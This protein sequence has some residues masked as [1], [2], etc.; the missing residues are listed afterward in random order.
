MNISDDREIII[1]IKK[2]NIDNFSFLVKKY[3]PK[4]YG[5]VY[6]KLFNK[7]EVDDLVQNAFFKF[8]KAIG[9]F[10]EQR[11]VLP[12]L[13]EIAKN[14]MKMYFRS[15]KK[16][17]NF[18]YTISVCLDYEEKF[19]SSDINDGLKI[20]NQDQRQ[21]LKLL[22]DGYSYEEIAKEINKPLNTVRTII[23]RGRLKMKK[24]YENA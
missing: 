6:G 20:L 22:S 12:Y 10:D 4:I 24:N 14:E 19:F 18:K 23:R 3:T 13:Y 16:T 5:Y 8:Y 21:A 1:K 9:R 2:G 17:V 15:R 7:D 11:P